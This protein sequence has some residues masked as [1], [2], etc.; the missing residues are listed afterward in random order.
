[1]TNACL[2]EV[3][4]KNKRAAEIKIAAQGFWWGN[5]A[6]KAGVDSLCG[7]EARKKML[8][9][10]HGETLLYANRLVAE[11]KGVSADFKFSSSQEIASWWSTFISRLQELFVRINLILENVD[12]PTDL[13]DQI[14]MK[15][16]KF[17]TIVCYGETVLLYGDLTLLNKNIAFSRLLSEK[18][19]P[20]A[21]NICYDL[22]TVNIPE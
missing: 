20:L 14:E 7:W 22:K 19:A 3:E 17:S 1:M 6:K 12:T 9:E 10:L 18:I 21:E 4:R 11:V 16:D 8:S 2:I 15:I 13:K 5:D